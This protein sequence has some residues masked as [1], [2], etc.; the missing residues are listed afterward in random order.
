MLDIGNVNQPEAC[1]LNMSLDQY[2]YV[3]TRVLTNNNYLLLEY[4]SMI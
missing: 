4:L 3:L 1:T 2:M